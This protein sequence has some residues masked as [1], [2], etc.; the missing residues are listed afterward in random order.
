MTLALE[1][2]GLFG[3]DVDFLER[4]IDLRVLARVL[5]AILRLQQVRKL[6]L[7]FLLV[8]GGSVVVFLADEVRRARRSALLLHLGFAQRTLSL[9]RLF[10]EDGLEPVAFDSNVAGK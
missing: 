1:G 10:L 3:V 2:L 8:L 9:S 6:A 4:L 5:G 7:R